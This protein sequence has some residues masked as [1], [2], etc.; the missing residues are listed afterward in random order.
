MYNP[1]NQTPFQSYLVDL[2]VIT[3]GDGGPV[4]GVELLYVGHGEVGLQ[5]H[6]LA[7]VHDGGVDLVDQ[8]VDLGAGRD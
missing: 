5:G 1:K 6:R 3:G 7:E 8:E 4:I 2:P